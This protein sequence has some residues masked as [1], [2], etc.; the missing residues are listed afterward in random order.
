M[1]LNRFLPAIALILF[2]M[3]VPSYSQSNAG[4]IRG[5]V[6]D[7]NG[8]AVQGA[9]VR[10]TNSVAKYEQ[11]GRTDASG[12]FKLIDVPFNHYLLTIEADGFATTNEDIV[13]TSNLV[14]QLDVKLS[15]NPVSASVNV[16]AAPEDLLNPNKT[17][18]SVVIDENRI[19][20]FPTSEPSRSTEKLIATAPGWTLDAQ[21]RLHARGIEYQV[22]YSIDGVPVT[23]T[24][25]STFASSPD[26]RNFRSVEIST[27]NVPAEYGNKTSGV[28]AVNTRS[29]LDMDRSGH[30]DFSGGTFDTQELSFDAGGHKKKFGWFASA[31]GLRTDRFLDPPAVENLHNH[32]VSAKSFLK[33]DYAVSKKDLLRFNFFVDRQ[34]FDVPNEPDQEE[35]GQ[36]RR[37]RT[38]DNMESLS[39]QHTFSPNTVSYLAFFQRYN[40]AK[41]LSNTEV[42]PVFAEQSRHNSTFGAVGSL[43]FFRKRNTIK[44]GFELTRFPVTESFSFAIT[45]LDELLEK[46]PDLTEEAQEF[47]LENPFFFRDH[48][49]GTEG[50]VYFQDHINATSKL[51]LDLGARFDSYHFLVTENFFSPRLAMAY[52]I[53]RTKTV[54]RA[55][56]NR[57][58]ETPALENLLLSS[59]ARS[60]IFSPASEEGG[61]TFAPVRPSHENQ[62]DIGF[63]QQLG[64]HL[65]LDVDYYF[66]HI[67]NQPEIINFVET[68]II[69]PATLDRNRSKGLETRLDLAPVKGFSGFVSYTNFHIYGFAPITG[70]LFLGEALDLLARS[71]ERI[72]IEEDQR[73]TAVFEARYDER[74]SHLWLAFGGRHDSGYSIELEPDAS[75][76]EFSAEFPVKILEQVNLERGFVKPHIVL[77]FS[78]GKEFK[79]SEHVG[80]TGQFNIENLT[81]KFYLITFESVFSGTTVGRPRSFSG[82]VSVSFK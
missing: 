67:K 18:P 52:Y 15:V 73:N 4:V 62:V 3:G 21:G 82:K 41:R 26:P 25:A 49:I 56:F 6:V 64:N 71:G 78:A 68:G 61:E 50:S 43:T 42:G 77:N 27:A 16:T 76:A 66:R 13:V 47:T 81:D 37:G 60:R 7:Q 54:L 38:W 8:A 45:D 12:A 51:T 79:I 10:L 53:P 2:S 74:R 1:S 29:G 48:H 30:V 22:Q 75:E 65:A 14:R 36:D 23:D 17:T 34:Q 55:S 58:M 39:W 5:T 44:T 46:Q 80:L 19:R 70:G 57:F 11:T 33:L 9:T 28:I 63:Q 35:E 59:S 72:N 24:M 69:F 40:S 32:G 20:T 31:A